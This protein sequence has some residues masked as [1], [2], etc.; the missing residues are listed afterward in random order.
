M[1]L[2]P[3]PLVRFTSKAFQSVHFSWLNSVIRHINEQNHGGADVRCQSVQ[4]VAFCYPKNSIK[5]IDREN[6][7]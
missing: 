6:D 3:R 7:S 5:S 4:S 1:V 2:S